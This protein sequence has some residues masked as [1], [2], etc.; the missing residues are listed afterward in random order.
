[1]T[2]KRKVIGYRLPHAVSPWGPVSEVR[3][4]GNG[5]CVVSTPSHGGYYVPDDMLEHIP[6][7]H[8]AIAA[9]WSG[10]EHWYEEDC[11][12]AYVCLV[13]QDLFP[14]EAMEHAEGMAG[15]LSARTTAVAPW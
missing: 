14:P 7:K 8:R 6:A 10:D 5:V 13:F 11:C 15:R 3:D 9:S 4:I 2:I 12:W 1:M